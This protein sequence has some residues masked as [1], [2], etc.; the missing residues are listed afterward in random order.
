MTRELVVPDTLDLVDRAE[1]ALNGLGGTLEPERDWEM[2]FFIRYG[3][4]EPY[5]YH[6]GFDPSNEPKFAESFP[7]MR[8]MTG[9]G[10][11]R[12]AE[13]GLWDQ[14]VRRLSPVDGLLWNH[15]R[16]DRPWHTVGHSGYGYP[17]R[18][19]DYANVYANGRML[20]AM[21]VRHELDGPAPWADRIQALVN[22]LDRIAIRKDDYA[23]FPDGGFGEAFSYPRGG[24]LR[25]DEPRSETEGGEGSVTAYQGHQMKALSQWHAVS[26]DPVALDLAA[27]LARFVMKPKFWGGVADATGRHGASMPSH[28]TVALPDPTCVAGAE[29]GHWYSHFHSRAVALRGLLEYAMVAGDHRAAEFVRQAWEYTW[30]LGVPRLGWVNCW[31]ASMTANHRCEGCALGDLVALG[32]RLS[33]AGM[34]DQWDIVDSIVRNHLV[35]QQLVRADTLEA[36]ARASPPGRAEGHPEVSGEFLPG[37]VSRESVIARSLGNFAG[38]STPASIPD[39]WVMQCCTGNGTQGLYY[40]WEGTLRAQAHAAA[41]N[42][43]LNHVSPRLDVRSHLPHRGKVVLNN[44]GLEKLAVRLPSWVRRDEV[45]VTEAGRAV[46]CFRAG[47]YLVLDTLRPRAEIHLDFPVPVSTARYT[48]AGGTPEETAYTCTFRGSTAVEVTPQDTRPRSYP[49]YQ[50][51]SMWA[52]HAPIRSVRRAVPDRVVRRW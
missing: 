43:L 48:V 18:D 50:R 38:A 51:A 47:N 29:Q 13:A 23:Y 24:W 12:A 52:D 9:S 1:L 44:H 2:Y 20:R 27:R 16:P 4:R 46:P 26:G 8:L 30:T 32:I 37:Q 49:L 34:G 45:R 31:P 17:V 19:E 15:A 33:D 7:L 42:L 28:V 5:M 36:I 6:W 3:C 41:L 39:P 40:A 22:G 10:T 35:E 25:T 14:L 11:H 21:L